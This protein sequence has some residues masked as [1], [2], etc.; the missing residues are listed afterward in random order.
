[1]DRG[2]LDAQPT[3]QRLASLVASIVDLRNRLPQSDALLVGIS[4]ID[5]SGKGYVTRRLD[6]R[7]RERGWSVATISADDWLNLPEICL[8]RNNPAEHFYEHALRLDGMFE[9]LVLPLKRNRS[10]DLVADCGGPKATRH[11]K[12][13]Y[14]FSNIDIVLIEG[15]FLFKPAYRDHFDL[16]IWIECSFE[17]ALTRAIA[18]GQEGLSPSQTR[19]AFE[20]IYFPAQRIHAQR[21]LPREAADI[22]FLNDSRRRSRPE[23]AAR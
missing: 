2:D 22:V 11:R 18:R 15:I 13:R 17:I 7:L 5:G 12:K 4:G 1:M 20:T 6:R 19:N 10:V 23:W 9:H 14:L 8:N 16:K 3:N 21:D